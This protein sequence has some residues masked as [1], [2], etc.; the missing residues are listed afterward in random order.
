MGGR[1][2]TDQEARRATEQGARADRE[3]GVGPFGLL[4]D[5]VEDFRIVHKI[6]LS[7]S[8]RHVQHVKLRRVGQGRICSEPKT[9]DVANGCE[10]LRVHSVCR[11]RETRQHFER[12]GETDLI[13]TFEQERTDVNMSAVV[14]HG[15]CTGDGL[16][17]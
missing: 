6:L 13:Q 12:A 15:H 7:E 17:S 2:T 16:I 3:Y 4:S 11:V 5:P 14:D 10:G 1:A 8:S 9:F